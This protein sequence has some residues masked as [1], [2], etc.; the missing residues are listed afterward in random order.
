M[1]YYIFL[2]SL[3]SLEEFRKNPHIKIPPKSSPTNFQS[4]GTFKN[5]IFIQKR[6]FPS[7]LDQSAQRPVGPAASRPI[8]S[9]GLATAT[10]FPTG[11]SPSPHWASAS[12]PAQPA[13]HR[14]RPARL[15]P[16]S[17]G[18]A[19]PRAAFTPLRARLIG[20]PHLS[21]P[22]SSSARA[23]PRRRRISTP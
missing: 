5:Q 21:S 1:A 3:R 14:W 23:Q 2:K 20:G 8:Q 22:S 6:I 12:R 9:F 13:T 7:L 19:S 15:P 18:N 11:R 10:F 17:W 4:I 16:P